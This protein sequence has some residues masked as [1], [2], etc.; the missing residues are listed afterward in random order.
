M[1]FT[2][3]L[4][5]NTKVVLKWITAS[6]TKNDYFTVEKSSN[7]FT[8]EEIAE[9]PGA[10]NSNTTLNYEVYDDDPLRGI[11]YYRLKQ[12]DYDGKFEYCNVVAVSYEVTTKG[13]CIL[14]VYPNP[15]I[16]YCTI[17]L[18]DC[19]DN[20]NTE[21]KVEMI[22]ALGNKVYST[23][24]YRSSEGSF[25]FSIDTSNSLKPGVYIV[26]GTSFNED[27]REKIIVK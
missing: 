5:D 24:P 15:C 23:I 12:T 17:D 6:E 16:G 25:S 7:G 11:S 4:V 19:K 22:D 18:S 20:E 9:V 13:T 8:F 21:I 10:G 26:R 2:A 1:S 3:T 27:Y 14:K